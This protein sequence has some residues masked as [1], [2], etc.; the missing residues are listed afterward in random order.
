MGLLIIYSVGS[1]LGSLVTGQAMAVS[2]SALFWI[3]GIMFTIYALVVVYRMKSRT[4]PAPEEQGD[5]IPVPL[6]S[7][8]LAEMDPRTEPAL[9]FD[10]DESAPAL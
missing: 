9:E 2:P 4:A 3:L 8:G 7:P 1:I 6:T 10:E 5:F